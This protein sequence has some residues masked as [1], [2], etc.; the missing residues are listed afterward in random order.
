M[1]TPS[2]QM[3]GSQSPWLVYG[4]PDDG[5]FVIFGLHYPGVG[6]VS[7]YRE[8][9]R[10]IGAGVFCPLQPPGREDRFHEPP[11]ATHRAYA[12]ALAPAVAEHLGRP[13][14]LI[15]HCGAFPYMLET[16]FRL[17]ELGLPLPHR[18][19]GSSW[20]APHRG[21]YGRLNFADLDTLDVVAEI[22]AMCRHRFGAELPDD[23]AELT[24]EVLAADLRVQRTFRYSGRPRVPSRTVVFGWSADD[25]V[26]PQ[27]VWPAWEECAD[28]SFRLLE[29]DHWEFLRC[30]PAL[31]EA[32]EA[33]M[34]AP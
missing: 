31:R 13:Y 17:Q 21:L 32:I 2:R 27:V 20:G 23:L 9:P 6:A 30:P 34:A 33:E 7:S 1:T 14:A 24:A 10:Q 18:L 25:V 15:G 4:P 12:E 8:W 28:V 26:P 3:A 5:D 11:L 22:Q 16:T 19:F 29:G